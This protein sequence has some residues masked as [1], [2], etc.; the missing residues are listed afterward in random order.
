VNNS[1]PYKT[2]GA[3]RLKRKITDKRI[4]K[5]GRKMSISFYNPIMC[6]LVK[7]SAFTMDT[8]DAPIKYI[9]VDDDDV[10]RDVIDAAAKKFPFLQK[11]AAFTNPVEALG[12]ISTSAP[13]VIF[14]DIEMPGL[15]G[16]E[17]LQQKPIT[18]ALIIF[19][20]SHPE[21]ALEGYEL[22]AF[23]Y[24][25]KPFSID[26]F[27]R[28]VARLHDFFQMKQKSFAYD[29]SREKDCI[30][31]KQGHDK[32]KIAIHDILFLEAMKDYTRI[33]TTNRQY[34][35]LSTL[36]AMKEKLP[37]ELFIQIHRSYVVNKD[38]VEAVEKNKLQISTHEL[39]IGKLYKH[40]LHFPG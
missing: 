28:C 26:R 29:A 31:V 18:S 11:M 2:T 15:T 19:I 4:S 9:T 16:I 1:F 13:D 38:K 20:T 40:A 12:F 25:I 22:Q 3:A 35:V 27:A 33:A 24:L 23:D 17:F 34:L 39:P 10:D 21:F 7:H 6:S 32:F 14:L 5:T 30:V 37:A 8:T 36:N